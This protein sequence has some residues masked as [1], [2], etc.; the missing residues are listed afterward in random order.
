MGA[1]DQQLEQFL[2]KLVEDEKL[3]PS[4]GAV[5]F[6]RDGHFVASAATGTADPET[7]KPFTL[8]TTVWFASTSKLSVSLVSCIL[9]EQHNVSLDSHSDLIKYVP[10]LERG[11]PGS[12][13]YEQWNDTKNEDGTWSTKSG[14]ELQDK[15]TLR[16]LLTHTFGSGYFFNSEPYAWA[17]ENLPGGPEMGTIRHM[18]IPRLK[19][20]GKEW[21]YQGKSLYLDEHTFP[22]MMRSPTGGCEWL[23]V[24]IARSSGLSVRGAFK[25]YLFE[26]LGVK[27]DTLDTFR[28][29]AMDEQRG[30]F[31]YAAGPGQ[32]ILSPV[33]FDTPQFEDHGPQDTFAMAS[34]PLWGTV[35]AYAAI[36]QALL[37]PEGPKDVRTGQ[38]LFSK[39]MWDDISSD[40]LAKHYGLDIQQK[41]FSK[42]AN[43]ALAT[44]VEW[45]F[46]PKQGETEQTLGWSALQTTVTRFDTS[47]GLRKGTLS[48]CGLANT[49]FFLDREQGIGGLITTQVFPW[50][51]ESSIQ[52]KNK[53]ERWVVENVKN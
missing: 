50:A 17:Y 34:A 48:W 25:K 19:E 22:L 38:P 47:S 15:P 42:T 32:F 46:E 4:L 18:D 37:Q 21:M 30:K 10:E 16:H 39:A 41:P 11:F 44:P 53:F 49:Y 33:Q 8:D 35:P 12:R 31:A 26:P 1:L 20:A 2:R 29:P 28:T 14:V 7:Q 3:A 24:F 45:Y 23:S 51:N 27:A 36:F 43:P 6:T 13:V 9:A 40:N 5:A 52:F